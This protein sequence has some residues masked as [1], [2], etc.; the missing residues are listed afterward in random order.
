MMQTDFAMFC[1]WDEENLGVAC[2]RI[3]PAEDAEEGDSHKS[4]VGKDA[5]GLR[6]GLKNNITEVVLRKREALH[7]TA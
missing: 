2:K 5:E 7:V 4:G 6:L 1:A 3:V